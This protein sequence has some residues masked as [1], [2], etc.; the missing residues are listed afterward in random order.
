MLAERT[1]QRVA[2]LHRVRTQGSPVASLPVLLEELYLLFNI[3]GHVL[4]DAAH[5]ETPMVPELVSSACD[6]LRASAVAAEGTSACTAGWI[7]ARRVAVHD[8]EAC[9]QAVKI[10]VSAA[11]ELA[12]LGG[13]ATGAAVT[14]PRLLEI[15][16][17]M[18]GRSGG[19]CSA[20]NPPA[21]RMAD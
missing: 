5:G 11:V 4:A 3:A 7:H 10:L 16:I 8:A 15:C 14:S 1:Q 18:L 2:E 19:C 9:A 20:V 6:P 17:W 13:H 12:K 21:T